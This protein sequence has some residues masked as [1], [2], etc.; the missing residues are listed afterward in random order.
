MGKV[1]QKQLMGRII[2]EMHEDFWRL[3]DDI[4]AD[5]E[6][7]L[8]E[9]KSSR[10][11]ADT[12]EARGFQVERGVAGMPTA[13]VASWRSG[14]GKPVV[15]LTAEYDALPHLSQKAGV[16]R[17][18]PL[19]EGAPGHGC[20][21][22]TM[23]AMQALV[24]SAIQRI[25]GQNDLD[26]TVK[27]LGCPAE[28]LTVSRPFM[29]REGLF[30]DVDLVIDCHADGVFK[31]TYGA[32]GTA[33]YSVLVTFT[34]KTS[35]AAWKP[36]MGRSAADAVELMHAGTE[37]MREH[38][39]PTSRTHWVTLHSGDAPNVVPDRAATWYFIRDLDEN[40][41][42]LVAWVKG[43]AEG[44]ALMT[45]TQ[46]ETRV[47]SAVHQRFYNRNLATLLFENIQEIGRPTYT[48]EEEAF[49]RALQKEAGYP[50]RGMDC[51]LALV[52][53]EKDEFRASS[54]DMGDVCLVVP[55][56]Q[57]SLP[58]WVPGSPA[59]HWTVASA[60]ATS[61]AHKGI[62]AGA[63]AVVFTVG[64]LISDADLRRRIKDE[65]AELARLRPYR[66]FLPRDVMPPLDFYAGGTSP[67]T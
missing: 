13:F 28:E 11:L 66:P 67:V 36:W 40:L 35:H 25:A 47:L 33:L 58:V 21:H 5:A 17:R 32:L 23:G 39:P 53:A 1:P 24:A 27:Y 19:I 26:I 49:A 63:K 7:G 16:P 42:A 12:L 41:E 22:N 54:S 14:T 29:V 37:R 3:S 15:G 8:M 45:Q 59:H 2:E 61:I 64:D 43:C 60:A 52:D 51:P 62:T 18:Q 50:V 20:G 38:L 65:F 31:T 30:R 46:Y 44:A 57:I 56:G 10:R 9:Y 48:A 6:L 4:W 34:G 55:T